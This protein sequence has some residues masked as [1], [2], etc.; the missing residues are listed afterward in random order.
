VDGQD[1]DRVLVELRLRRRRI[2]TDLGEEV[3][4]AG[5]GPDGVVL[6]ELREA[7][8][9]VEEESDVLDPDLGFRGHRADEALEEAALFE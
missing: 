8:D 4:I 1:V 7:L 3:E 6:D 5:E 9:L 2:V